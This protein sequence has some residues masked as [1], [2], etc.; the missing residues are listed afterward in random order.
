MKPDYFDE[1]FSIVMMV[2]FAPLL[3]PL[4]ILA[5]LVWLIGWVACAGWRR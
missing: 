2:I 3:I 1:G 4:A 5:G